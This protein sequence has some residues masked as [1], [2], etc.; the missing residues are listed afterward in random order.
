M[1]EE[2]GQ[3]VVQEAVEIASDSQN[4]SVGAEMTESPDSVE[5]DTVAEDDKVLKTPKDEEDAKRLGV[6]E[7]MENAE[8]IAIAKKDA[9]EGAEDAEP[10][11]PSFFVDTE[12]RHRVDVDILCNKKDGQ[13]LS[14]S[15]TGLGINYE[16]FKYLTHVSEW[17]EFTVP[18]Y[19]D[20]SGY[21][22]RCGAYRPE[23]QQVLIDRLQLRNFLLVWHLKDWS[24]R[25]TDGEVVKLEHDKNGS[26]SD[27]SMKMV[28]KTHTTILDVA[29][30][31]FEKDILLS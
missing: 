2:Q 24:L 5:T 7:T 29:L 26:L 30:T 3:E 20:M 21:R 23:A 10:A 12:K 15:R 22:Q 25:T 4:E 14:V 6:K 27:T 17:F 18:T 31:I 9:Q 28:Y 11:A 19:E 8:A 16:E 1:K 13:I